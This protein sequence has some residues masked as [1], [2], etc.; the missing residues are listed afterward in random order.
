MGTVR[1]AQSRAE[2]VAG[3]GYAGEK[4]MED[5][6]GDLVDNGVED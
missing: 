2:A 3:V 5:R 6:E 4:A 1:S